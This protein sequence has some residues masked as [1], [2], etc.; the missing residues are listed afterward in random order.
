MSHTAVTQYSNSTHDTTFKKKK[1]IEI[2][3]AALIPVK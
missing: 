2:A 1:K 3:A